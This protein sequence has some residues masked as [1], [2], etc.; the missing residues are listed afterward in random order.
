LH[1][2]NN[3]IQSVLDTDPSQVKNRLLIELFTEYL[4][5]FIVMLFLFLLWFLC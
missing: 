2:K 3:V 1:K 4:H 5:R